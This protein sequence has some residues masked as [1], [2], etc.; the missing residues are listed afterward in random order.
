MNWA[1]ALC[2]AA[3][4][5]MLPLS[6]VSAGEINIGDGLIKVTPDGV[7]VGPVEVDNSGAAAGNDGAATSGGGKYS[8]RSLQSSDFSNSD[9]S[10]EDFSNSRLISVD[11]SNADLSGANFAGAS[12]I[13][14]DL[15]NAKLVGADFKDAKLQGVDFG[16]SELRKACL[17]RATLT[18]VDFSNA[19][20]SEAVLTG[21]KNLGSDFSN[22]T[23]EGT[24]WKGKTTCPGGSAALGNSVTTRCGGNRPAEPDQG[25][26][27]PESP[28][29]RSQR[30]GRPDCQ[31]RS[32]FRQ[33]TGRRAR[34]G[35][36]N[37]Q[38]PEI[39]RA[40]VEHDPDRRPHGQHRRRQLQYGPVVPPGDQRHEGPLG[41][42]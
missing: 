40:G 9:L 10:G 27:H 15:S 24:V 8:G 12:L 1:K 4:T 38:G 7:K 6:G 23:T 36:R 39:G 32:R 18:G 3:V 14:V 21:S 16:N 11:F 28:I 42:V 25:R 20:L 19:D 35:T 37:R 29:R 34:S 30:E 22:A 41:G 5:V 2:A 31:F 13:G 26:D 17:V 33:D